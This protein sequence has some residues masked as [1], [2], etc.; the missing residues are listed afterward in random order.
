[1]W[2]RVESGMAG[3]EERSPTVTAHVVTPVRGWL[4]RGCDGEG[5]GVGEAGEKKAPPLAL[6]K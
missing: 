4:W 1:M 3:R 5:S 2:V 6:S